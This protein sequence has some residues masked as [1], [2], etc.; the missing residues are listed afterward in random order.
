MTC[1]IATRIV[2]VS[3]HFLDS[4]QM[5]F[6]ENKMPSLGNEKISPTKG[7]GKFRKSSTQNCP[8]GESSRFSGCKKKIPLKQLRWGSGLCDSCYNKSSTGLGG[9]FVNDGR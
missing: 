3:W 7:P 9:R 6:L 5:H 1:R 2:P 8:G 4:M